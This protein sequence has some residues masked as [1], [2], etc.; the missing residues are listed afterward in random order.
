MNLLRKKGV[1]MH[2]GRS[3]GFA[4]R[5]LTGLLAGGCAWV[6]IVDGPVDDLLGSAEMIFR[7]I[8][9]GVAA[10]MLVWL[11]IDLKRGRKDENYLS[12][13]VPDNP[14]TDE[15]LDEEIDESIQAVLQKYGDP[16]SLDLFGKMLTDSRLLVRTY[17]HADILDQSLMVTTSIDYCLDRPLA[18]DT[19]TVSVPVPVIEAPKGRLLDSFEVFGDTGT[20]STLPQREMRGLLAW[21]LVSYYKVA[22]GQAAG[23]LFDPAS[24]P[25]QLKALLRT[26]YRRGRLSS[27]QAKAQYEQVIMGLTVGTGRIERRFAERLKYLCM[28]Y[29]RHYVVGVDIHLDHQS[30]RLHLKYRQLA[31]I[32]GLVEDWRS[33]LRARLGLRPYVFKL[34]MPMLYRTESYH[35]FMRGAPGQYVQDH[36]IVDS[37]SNTR[38][39]DSLKEASFAECYLRLRHKVGLPYARVY[40]RGFQRVDDSRQIPMASLVTFA[41]VP[42]G[43]LGG[44]ARVLMVSTALVTLFAFLRPAV[45]DLP[46]DGAALLLAAPAAIATWVGH[47]IER[48][49]QSSLS[50][51]FGLLTAQVLSVSSALLYLAERRV[52]DWAQRYLTVHDQGI[53]GFWTLPDFDAAWLALSL[54]GVAFT[55]YLHVIRER[56]TRTYLNAVRRWNSLE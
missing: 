33:T 3:I 18:H 44:A 42:P 22:Y 21:T 15:G 43:A 52:P 12:K 13:P 5:L 37:T 32:Y 36:C 7:L 6:A 25:P 47:S 17:E 8:A 34:P 28:F 14:D 45:Q 27:S 54:V 46:S 40:A 16:R 26:I 1:E 29:S 30:T 2:L 53:V 10:T 9:A 50:T 24:R 49:R 41:E 56:C 4:G 20:M 51:Y 38:I 19:D 31:P 48:V 39:G 23:D 35:F 55:L 11:L